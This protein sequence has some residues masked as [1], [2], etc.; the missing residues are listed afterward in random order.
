[1]TASAT[2]RPGLELPAVRGALR[3]ALAALRSRLRDAGGAVPLQVRARAGSAERARGSAAGRRRRRILRPRV[4][5]SADAGA[6]S[7]ARS[8]RTFPTTRPGGHTALFFTNDEGFY[9][10]DDN[11][12]ASKLREI[13]TADERGKLLEST[14]RSAGSCA[15]AGS[16]FR[17]ACRR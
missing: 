16:T 14:A 15:V 1:M 11:V 3:P 17:A 13:E 7:V 10:L 9:V 2:A 4:L 8:G 6:L 5:G 12:A